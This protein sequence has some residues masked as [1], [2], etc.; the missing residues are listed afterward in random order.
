VCD[1]LIFY[2]SLRTDFAD[3]DPEEDVI[4]QD[5]EDSNG[6]EDSDDDLVGTEHYVD[7]GLVLLWRLTSNY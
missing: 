2:S 1:R 5:S 3:F 6:S 7:V 4:A